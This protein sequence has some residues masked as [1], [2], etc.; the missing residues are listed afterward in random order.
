MNWTAAMAG[1]DISGNEVNADTDNNGKATLEEAFIYAK[2]HTNNCDGEISTENRYL[3]E[4]IAFNNIPE[5]VDLY[6]RDNT[7]D[8]GKEPSIGK[9]YKSPDIWFRN[10]PDGMTKQYDEAIRFEEESGLVYLYSRVWNSGIPCLP[11]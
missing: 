9:Y 7:E 2:N 11:W 10:N 5:A 6:M 4:D 1:C 8:T 3:M